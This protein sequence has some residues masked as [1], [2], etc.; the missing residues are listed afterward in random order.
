MKNAMKKLMSLLLVAVLLVSAIPFGAS[1]AMS[2]ADHFDVFWTESNDGQ[3]YITCAILNDG[4]VD[5]SGVGPKLS[6]ID[7]FMSRLQGWYIEGI[8]T[9]VS[10]LT[11]IVPSM[12]PAGSYNIF[13]VLAAAPAPQT[14]TVYVDAQNSTAVKAFTLTVGEPVSESVIPS[15]PNPGKLGHVFNGW[16]IFG[17]TSVSAGNIVSADW[18]GQ[19][20]KAN[21][22]IVGCIECGQTSGHLAGC[23]KG[24]PVTPDDSTTSGGSNSTANNNASSMYVDVI[25]TPNKTSGFTS[26]DYY[27]CVL[28]DGKITAADRNAV[29]GL[30]AGKN[31]GAW[32]RADNGTQAY[33]LLDFDFSGL[34]APINILPVVNTTSGTTNSGTTNSGTT[35]SGTTN[36]GVYN[37]FPYNVYLNIYKDTMVGSP[38]KCIDI[39]SGIALDGLV[40]LS[41][42]KTVVANYY[43]AKNSYGIGYDGLYL[44]SGNWVANYVADTQKY[45]EIA[46]GAMRQTGYVYINVMIS[47]ATAKTTATA[48]SSNPKTGDTIYTA[49]TVMG[50]SAASLAAV[51]Y[52]YNKKRMAL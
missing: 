11:E 7:G 20:I 2:A 27:R 16:T 10:S 1:A 41:E 12:M 26:S 17:G 46:A 24:T 13:P 25:I 38:D 3:S 30:I 37:K 50:L 51:M 43:N 8:G 5:W 23:N 44:A 32:K 36:S 39:T 34:K 9:T 42:V 47:N 49:M 29:A 28:V 31:I 19:T 48:D 21:W 52:F 18:N 40:S 15:D 45:D 35:N 22:A 14:V 33:T 4:S 6:S